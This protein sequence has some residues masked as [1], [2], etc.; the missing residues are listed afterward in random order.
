MVGSLERPQNREEPLGVG[1]EILEVLGLCS[2]APSMLLV[3]EKSFSRKPIE[4]F[5]PFQV[6]VRPWAIF[7]NSA[8]FYWACCILR[9]T[10]YCSIRKME[11]LFNQIQNIGQHL[12]LVTIQIS[13]GL[14]QEHNQNM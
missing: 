5:F 1:G 13:L 10:S 3:T 4:V 6:A 2:I 8:L 14:A 7:N 12:S 9:S 11:K